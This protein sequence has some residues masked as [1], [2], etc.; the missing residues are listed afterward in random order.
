[1]SRRKVI[2]DEYESAEDEV[3]EEAPQVSASEDEAVLSS[4]EDENTDF[5]DDDEDEEEEGGGKAKRSSKKTK[6]KRSEKPKKI[7]P[8]IYQRPEDLLE[9]VEV[10]QAL[11]MKGG[12]GKETLNQPEELKIVKMRDYQLE[13]LTWMADLHQ[14]VFSF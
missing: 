2:E 8:A 3:M 12:K 7:S 14:K 13:G 10:Y 1:M 9:A 11:Q 4:S 5:D 6:V